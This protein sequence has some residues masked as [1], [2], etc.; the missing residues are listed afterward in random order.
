M[1]TAKEDLDNY[2]KNLSNEIKEELLQGF[3]LTV[4]ELINA[5]DEELDE[6]EAAHDDYL[7]EEQ[8]TNRQEIID[9]IR[10]YL[11]LIDAKRR[12]E[13]R[14]NKHEW[15]FDFNDNSNGN[16]R[17][18][19]KKKKV[20][21]PTKPVRKIPISQE[22]YSYNALFEKYQHLRQTVIDNMPTIW[23]AL[24]FAL[25]VKSIL[26]IK[27]NTLPFGGIILGVASSLKTAVIELFRDCDHVFYT[28]NFSAKAFVSHVSG[29]D[30]ERL[31]EIDMLPRI[32]DNLFLTPELAP[33]FAQREEDLLQ[34][35]GIMTRILDGQG[36]EN[37]TGAQGHRGYNE[38]I[39]FTWI[40]AS[41]EIPRKVHR[42]LAVLG[43]RLYFY[44]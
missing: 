22:P 36:Y 21:E 33:T 29:V 40:G 18:K 4:E 23:P 44:R 24:E 5:K 2:L 13:R 26:N 12:E 34:T 17:A 39:M 11:L 28:D 7:T 9:N 35:I 16:G 32:K 31:K 10:E 20:V 1:T 37:D 3:P 25:S 14:E 15:N 19:H 38:E 43:P 41:V 6:L 27:D 42:Q 30:K 8:Q